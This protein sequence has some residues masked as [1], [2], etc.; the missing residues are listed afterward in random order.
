MQIFGSCAVRLRQPIKAVRLPLLAKLRRMGF[1]S[2]LSFFARVK[3]FAARKVF[4]FFHR[5]GF[6]GKGSASLLIEGHEKYFPFRSANLQTDSLYHPL[7]LPWFEPDVTSLIDVLTKENSVFY[8]IGSNWGFHS[9]FLA[10]K[11]GFQGHIHAFEPMPDTFN[12]LKSAVESL[13]LKGIT[14]HNTALSSHG[15][16]AKMA[17]PPDRNSGGASLVSSG[18]IAVQLTALDSLGLRDPDL[19]KMDVEGHE[20]EALTGASETLSRAKPMIIFE[21]WANKNSPSACYAPIEHLRRA[22]YR[23]FVPHFI[24]GQGEDKYFNLGPDGSSVKNDQ[25]TLA[26]VE[27]QTQERFLFPGQINLLAC[28]ES[29]LNELKYMFPDGN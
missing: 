15:G 23:L 4:S 2:N 1:P 11:H 26:L 13:D 20:V 21:N 17:M 14:L 24:C 16:A 25:A 6:G 5:L 27:M 22:G 7:Y 19:I 18:N 10:S 8:D 9:L 28:H 3:A 12:D 29:K